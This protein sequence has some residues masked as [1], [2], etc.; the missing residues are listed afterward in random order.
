[1]A[2]QH[3]PRRHD[4]GPLRDLR[5][6]HAVE[7]EAGHDRTAWRRSQGHSFHT[8]AVGLRLHRR[9]TSRT[10]PTRSSASSAPAPP[11]CRSIPNLGEPAPR[12][13]TSSS[14]RRR[15]STSRRLG[16]RS[17]VGGDAEAGLAGEAR[18]EGDDRAA[19][20]RD[21]GRGAGGDVAR[22]EDPPP[23]ERQHRLHDADPPP[24]RRDRRGPGDGRRAQALVHVHVQAAVLPQRVP[25]DVQPTERAPRRHPRQGHHRDRTE[26]AR[27]SRARSTSSTC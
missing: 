18:A 11:R 9:R 23:G 19:A 20:H 3:R 22:G 21:P 15:R 26:R 17:G 25:A 7:A 1:M 16:D 12:S 5:Q 10:S 24:H 4:A 14:A 6:R 27:S 2:R 8:V 13:S